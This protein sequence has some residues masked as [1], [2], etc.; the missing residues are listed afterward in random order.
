MPSEF[1]SLPTFGRHRLARLGLAA[2]T[3]VVC[4]AFAAD[5]FISAAR[6][7]DE[8]QHPAIAELPRIT[9]TSR[10][11]PGD[12]LNV[13]FVG[14][15]QDL[16]LALLTAGWV[17]ADPITLKSSLRLAAGTV[18]HRSYVDAPVSNL[19]LW[20]RKQDLAFERPLGKD[21]RRRHH[22]R[23][24]R[25][26]R[27]D[28]QGRP[29][30]IGAATFDT[31]VGLSHT[32]GQITHHIAADVDAEREKLVD[33]LKQTEYLLEVYAVDKFH[34]KLEGKNGGGDKWH[35]DGRLAVGVVGR[36]NVRADRP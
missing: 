14:S 34:R 12:P 5:A 31:K 4:C 35:T 6:G 3:V 13:A 8:R 22:V 26:E 10:G 19:F 16:Q 36:R 15:E 1:S 29:L 18:F 25:S 33:D 24:W 21:P 17:P 20:G 28:S 7:Q 27:L 32:T 2:A 23:F 9:R 11:I 30:W